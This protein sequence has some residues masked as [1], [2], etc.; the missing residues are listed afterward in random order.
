MQSN[1]L[2]ILAPIVLTASWG[3]RHTAAE[4]VHGHQTEWGDAGACWGCECPSYTTQDGGRWH[5]SPSWQ[6]TTFYFFL[7][8]IGEVGKISVQGFMG[9]WLELNCPAQKSICLNY[10]IQHFWITKRSAEGSRAKTFV[11]FCYALPA[12]NCL[13]HVEYGC[14]LF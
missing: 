14:T 2:L 10:D 6:V 9:F 13:W 3:A 4:T 11:L 12:L 1:T 5:A 8:Y 7:I